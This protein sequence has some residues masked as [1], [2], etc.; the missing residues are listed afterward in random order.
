MSGFKQ[1]QVNQCGGGG[2]LVK[3]SGSHCAVF[4]RESAANVK[5]GS[6]FRTNNGG[7]EEGVLEFEKQKF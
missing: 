3:A 5:D 2:A 1:L 6:D 7:R 4:G